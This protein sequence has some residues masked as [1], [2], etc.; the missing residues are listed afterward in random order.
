M[1]IFSAR[2]FRRRRV[3]FT[4]LQVATR[5]E[6]DFRQFQVGAFNPFSSGRSAGRVKYWE[7]LHM[8]ADKEHAHEL[9][10]RL[11]QSQVPA[12]VGILEALLDPVSRAIAN[13]PVDDEPETEEE[14]QAVARSKAWFKQ[15]GGQGIPHEEVLA[16]F[17]QGHLP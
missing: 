8:A 10:D 4:P 7:E 14:R 17:G 16:E 13:A 1:L 12:V 5:N 15:R 6:R 2:L 11:A 9:I 3:A